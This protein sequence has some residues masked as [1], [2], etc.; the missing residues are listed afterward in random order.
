M[1]AV[2]ILHVGEDVTVGR[3]KTGYWFET[4]TRRA[5]GLSKTHREKGIA[6]N[7]DA[8]RARPQPDGRR[9]LRS[10][11]NRRPRSVFLVHLGYQCC[12]LGR[13]YQSSETSG[14]EVENRVSVTGDQSFLYPQHQHDKFP[15][16]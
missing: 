15:W 13:E 12:E 10:T 9:Q 4:T 8:C 7:F 6:A 5:R 11:R 3:G 16:S 14:L 1:E 2:T